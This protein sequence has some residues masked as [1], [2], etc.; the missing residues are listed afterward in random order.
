V[1]FITVT[2][3]H[4]TD[5]LDLSEVLDICSPFAADLYERTDSDYADA[6]IVISPQNIS[7]RE[8]HSRASVKRICYEMS[9]GNSVHFTLPHQ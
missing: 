8:H 7:V 2:Q 5:A 1:I 3:G 6:N 9:S 4:N